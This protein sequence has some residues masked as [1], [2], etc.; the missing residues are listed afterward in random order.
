MTRSSGSFV[1][2][3]WMFWIGA[4]RPYRPGDKGRRRRHTVAARRG[5]AEKGARWPCRAAAYAGA[6]GRVSAPTEGVADEAPDGGRIVA[7]EVVLAA[8]R[9]ARSLDG[10]SR[11]REHLEAGA[12]EG[13][14]VLVD[15]RIARPDVLV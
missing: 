13:D 6:P 14:E 4:S 3:V 5:R 12:V 7:L 8:Q 9:R 15:E 2:I 10:A 1:W 11:Q